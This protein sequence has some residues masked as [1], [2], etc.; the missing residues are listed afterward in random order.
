MT[1]AAGTPSTRSAYRLALFC[2]SIL[3]AGAAGCRAQPA[4]PHRPS[5]GAFAPA[6]SRS[7]RSFGAVGGGQANDTA[8]IQRAL[9]R[10][11]DFCL[12]GEGRTY[13]V[14]GTLR[15]EHDLCLRNTTLVQAIPPVDT[16]PYVV[17]NCPVTTDTSAVVDCGDP[18]IGAAQL[19][20]L[21]QWLSVRTLFIRRDGL[22]IRLRVNL[23]HVK[24]D[25]GRSPEQGSR[26]DSAGIW[27]QNASRIDLKSVEITGN[28]KGYG[29]FV[30]RA[31]DIRVDGLWIHDLVW[32]PYRGDA[33]L[34]VSRASRIG[35]NSV[36][37]REFREAGL[38]GKQSKFY[39][40]RVQEQLTCAAFSEVAA[41]RIHNVRISRCMAQFDGGPLPWQADGL[42][43]SRSS[44]DVTIDGAT[45]DS[46]WEGMDI[47][48]NGSGVKKLAIS[49]ATVTN[50]FGF[51]L[52]LGRDV[53][54]ARLSNIRIDRAGVAG[55]VLYGGVSDLSISHARIDNVGWL[56]GLGGRKLAPW[57]PGNRSGIRLDGKAGGA[58]GAP[59]NV[60][61]DDVVIGADAGPA[62]YD[63]GILNTGGTAIRLRGFHANG[64]GHSAASGVEIH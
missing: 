27:I 31:N 10:S 57:P 18:A 12:D 50:S 21:N 45:I 54:G 64:Y 43:I 30:N 59:A 11:E 52:K 56:S 22:D 44:T 20:R 13:K 61:V 28:G 32:A 41:V 2:I 16:S 48:G 39:G 8:A 5:D 9:Q 38:G 29:L 55:V 17:G 42:D 51:G 3:V 36:P 33:P 35:W 53:E 47:V 6:Q 34:T 14:I 62:H 49:N 40:V 24:I 23:D 58:S 46:T 15:A 4:P 1:R 25:R 60:L 63:F 7:L 37:V 19:Q 26:T